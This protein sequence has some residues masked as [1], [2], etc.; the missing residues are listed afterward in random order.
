MSSGTPRALGERRRDKSIPRRGLSAQRIGG[1]GGAAARLGEASSRAQPSGASG[2]SPGGR[3]QQERRGPDRP[4]PSVGG[5]PQGARTHQTR[6]LW[7]RLS[8]TP[9]EGG[10]SWRR[11]A[12]A[13][14]RRAV[15]RLHHQTSQRDRDT[16]VSPPFPFGAFQTK[17]GSCA[18][19]RGI[20]WP[21]NCWRP[22]N[23][24]ERPFVSLTLA[25]GAVWVNTLPK[26]RDGWDIRGDR[27]AVPGCGSSADPP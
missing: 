17:A 5:H 9:G 26:N 12:P 10:G 25:L 7:S 16:H 24:D 22:A 19:H 1:A 21:Q 27:D 18:S 2:R 6:R 4:D 8:A 13:G 14:G 15:P 23:I 11:G 3:S 20:R